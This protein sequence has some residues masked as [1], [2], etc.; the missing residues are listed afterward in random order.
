MP[1]IIKKELC[2]KCHKCVQICPLDIFEVESSGY[3]LIKYPEECWH[4]NSCVFDCPKHAVSLRVPLPA[5]MLYIDV[6]KDDG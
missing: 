3:P 2:I 4:C 1:P 6:T 5:S